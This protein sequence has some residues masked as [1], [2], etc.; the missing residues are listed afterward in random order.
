MV[1][2]VAGALLLAGLGSLLLAR[3]ATREQ[4]RSD[5]VREATSLA[6][7]TEDVQ[8]PAVTKVIQQV[9]KLEG[10]AVIRYGVRGRTSDPLPP[11]LTTADIRPDDLFAGAVVSGTRGHLAFA[12][13]PVPRSNG[14]TAVVLTRRI[15]AP[16]R[17]TGYFLL[18]AGLALAVA[19][20]VAEWLSAQ[21]VKPLAQAEAATKRVANGELTVQVPVPSRSSPELSSLA[22]SINTMADNLNRAKGLERQFLLSVSHDLR[23][24]LTSIRGFA[25]AIADGTATD[26]DRAASVIA[27]EAR[28]LERLVKDL[29]DLA[30]LEARQF[31][32]DLQPVDVSEV[33]TDTAEGFVPEAER[34]GVAV[35]V[36]VPSGGPLLALADPERLAQVVANLTEN[37]LK[38]AATA[39]DVRARADADRVVVTVADDGPGI[40][41]G[42][43]GRVFER[44]YTSAR[45]PARHGVGS[46]LGLAI[47]AELVGAMG[48][49]VRAESPPEGGTVVRVTLSSWSSGPSSSTSSSTTA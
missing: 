3:R 15:P 29:L 6:T 23:T 47:V 27:A 35:H 39:I 46:G 2:V 22:T 49:A 48:G 25:E 20:A 9:L 45:T 19:F 17:S 36:D 16:G 8:R 40:A 30:K 28:R 21:I 18:A 37:A 7:G 32:F 4:T 11:G 12:A 41:V 1:G 26:V 44:L 31:S 13:A 33:V 14:V 43:L 42:E 24:P 5:L 10:Y 34:E 38:F